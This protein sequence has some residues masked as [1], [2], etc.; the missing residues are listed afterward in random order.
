MHDCV[1]WKLHIN[2]LFSTA[3]KYHILEYLR[4]SEIWLTCYFIFLMFQKFF[5]VHGCFNITLGEVGT[6]KHKCISSFSWL[7]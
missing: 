5:S 1:F 3:A 7:N 6:G 2:L 4:N